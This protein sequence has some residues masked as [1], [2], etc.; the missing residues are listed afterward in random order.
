MKDIHGGRI[1]GMVAARCTW[2]KPGLIVVLF[3]IRW[4][5]VSTF[6]DAVRG[7]G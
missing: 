5:T 7:K 2:G 3:K 4:R 6:K 1:G